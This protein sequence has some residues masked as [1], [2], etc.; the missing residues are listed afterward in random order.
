[1]PLVDPVTMSSA[2]ASQP[3]PVKSALPIELLPNSFA[4]IYSQAHPAL[5]LSAYYFQFPAF[6]ANPTSSLL[7]SLAPLALTQ[8]VYAVICLPAVG[9]NAKLVKKVKLNA[10]KKVEPASPK[11]FASF[12][13]TS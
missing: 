12:P 1:M 4:R 3:A 10:S 6:V 2:G 13:L 7:N 8:V 9:S 5:L 11:L